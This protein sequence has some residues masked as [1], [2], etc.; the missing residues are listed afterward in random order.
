MKIAALITALALAGG[1]AFAAGNSSTSG[2]ASD[3]QNQSTATSTDTQSGTSGANGGVI[4]KTKRALHRVGGATRNTMHR[5]G[6]AARR[7][8]H[9]GDNTAASGSDTRSMGASGSGSASD[10]QDSARRARMDQAYDNWR[11]RQK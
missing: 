2:A 10:T 4:D 8:T 1:C 7:T 6:N 3:Y 9:G 5:I 11:S